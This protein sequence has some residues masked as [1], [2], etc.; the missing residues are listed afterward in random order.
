M[1]KHEVAWVAG[2]IEGEGSLHVVRKGDVVHGRVAVVMTDYDV[3]ESLRSITGVGTVRQ[4]RARTNR[5]RTW[6][7][8]F[9]ARED[10]IYLVT[11]IYPFLH[12]RRKQQADK[13]LEA[14][15]SKSN[16]RDL[17]RGVYTTPSGRYRSSIYR[18]G[19]NFCLGTFDTIAEAEQAYKEKDQEC[20]TTEYMSKQIRE[21]V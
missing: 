8:A 5:K 1:E 15:R 19:E 9:A 7:W 21:L 11:L 17:P 10:V 20:S 4:E 13:V 3:L 16:L 12:A 2:I 18:N 6:V 14:S